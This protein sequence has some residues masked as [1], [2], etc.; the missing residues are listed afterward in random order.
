MGNFTHFLP[1]QKW[2]KR[3]RY[4]YDRIVWDWGVIALIGYSD[5]SGRVTMSF[6]WMVP[7][8]AITVASE[9]SLPKRLDTLTVPLYGPL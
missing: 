5:C 4:Y 7:G 6:T 9:A 2:V 8:P 1:G 3:A